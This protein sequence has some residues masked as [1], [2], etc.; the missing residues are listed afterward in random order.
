[1]ITFSIQDGISPICVASHYG[2]TDVVDVLLR[3]GAD[4][5]QSCTTVC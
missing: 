4:A 1:M 2:H 3:A 5:N